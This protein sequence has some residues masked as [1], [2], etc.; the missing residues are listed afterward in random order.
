MHSS[1]AENEPPNTHLDPECGLWIPP[2][3]REFES[4][5][6]IRTPRATIQHFGNPPLDPYYGMVDASHF[7]DTEEMRDP[8]NPDLAPDRIRI[9]PQGEDA[10]E[11][12][13]DRPS[14]DAN[15]GD[16]A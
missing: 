9:K 13:V 2:Q 5:I 11:L 8:K 12:A 15:R 14:T 4:Q 6:V 10:T 16:A 7:G 1:T 3:F